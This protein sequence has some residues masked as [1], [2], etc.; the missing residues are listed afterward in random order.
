MMVEGGTILPPSKRYKWVVLSNTT[1]GVFLALFN[2]SVVIISLPAIFRGIGVDPLDP[3]N[4]GLLLWTL[5]GYLVVTAVLVVTF[6]RIGDIYGRVRM[7][8]AGFVIF[9][10]ASLALG[11]SPATGTAG[12]WVIIVLRV[13]Q[14]VGGALLMANSTAILTD[15][16]DVSERGMA[17]GLNVVAGISGSFIGL[18]VGGLVSG[19]S[20]RLVFLVSVPVGLI[21]TVWAYR[22]LHETSERHPA[23]IDWWGNVTFALG[24]VL[25]LVGMTYAIQ[26]F[27]GH[28]MGWTSPVVL[29]SLVGGC[30]LMAVFVWIERHVADPLL[31]LELFSS[32][33][34]AG[35][36]IA[37]LFAN[38]GRGGLQFLLIIW[39][40]GIWLPL[41]GYDFVDTPLW[42]GLYLIPLSVGFLVAG[43]IAGILSDRHGPRLLTTL[44]MAVTAT[45]FL[46]LLVLPV[47]FGYPGF[48][49]ILLVNGI[50][51]GA[52]S[53]PNTSMMMNAVPAAR[54]GA[55]SGIRATFLN[56][57]FVLSIG[58]FFSLMVVGLAGSLPRAIRTGL[59][60][61]G[62]SPHLAA[63]VASLP[64]VGILFSAFLGYNPLGTVLGASLN[65]LTLQQRQTMTSRSFF[66]HLIAGPFHE[67]LVVSMSVS[68]VL[69]AAA[70]VLSWWAG[71]RSR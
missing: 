26:P 60:A 22:A 55:A 64:P 8:N 7:Y 31:H 15:A 21:G 52:F 65:D 35:G 46:A 29:G 42:A 66:P 69:C 71:G 32:R 12:A 2:S 40:Q 19:V 17:L 44:G 33:A 61:Q 11:L 28:P 62:V 30:V 70:A 10:I 14:G 57:G 20:W 36:G 49:L 51:T 16:F 48:A 9:T 56:S 45:T 47:N 1:L 5:Q 4:I 59:A 23:R 54:R 18:I 43:P 68:A 63:H 3:S 67:G 50:G 41:H 24:L 13:V 38:M 58:L 27:D 34:F 53:A 37:N 39:L 6:G 25:I